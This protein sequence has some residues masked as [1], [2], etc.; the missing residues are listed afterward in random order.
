VF[1]VDQIVRIGELR[2][3]KLEADGALK[4]R[5][6]RSPTRAFVA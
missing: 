4:Q 3:G 5:D 2:N 6:Q 1:R